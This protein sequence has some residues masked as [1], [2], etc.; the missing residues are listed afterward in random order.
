[1]KNNK[2]HNGFERKEIR[3]FLAQSLIDADVRLRNN[4]LE[5]IPY[6][7]DKAL[8]YIIRNA[9]LHIEF[10]QKNIQIYKQVLAIQQLI[11]LNNW[12]ENDVSNETEK[13]IKEGW[14][15]FI[16]TENEYNHLLEI[17]RKI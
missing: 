8:E 4:K 14:M 13:D 3:D 12:Q 6:S 17:I 1:M 5:I 7:E 16:G 2:I 15:S 10:L 11:A 9:E